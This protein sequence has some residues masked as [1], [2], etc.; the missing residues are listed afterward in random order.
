MGKKKK[1]KKK[2]K[3]IPT[4]HREIFLVKKEITMSHAEAY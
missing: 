2:K 4:S 1:K 3:L